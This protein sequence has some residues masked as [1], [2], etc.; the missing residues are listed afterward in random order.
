MIELLGF[1][2]VWL[3]IMAL[4]GVALYFVS[5]MA[6]KK[7]TEKEKQNNDHIQDIADE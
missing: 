6:E 3:G 5:R 1:A 4:I 7:D 2:A